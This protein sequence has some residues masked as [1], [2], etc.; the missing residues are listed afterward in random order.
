MTKINEII[1]NKHVKRMPVEL[2]ES[3]KIF[4]L[5]FCS[6]NILLFTG[7]WQIRCLFVWLIERTAGLDSKQKNKHFSRSTS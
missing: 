7:L 2:V 1:N 3:D 6:K 5:L 4:C